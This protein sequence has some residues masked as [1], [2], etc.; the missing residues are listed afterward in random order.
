VATAAE[1]QAR[2]R[3]LLLKPPGAR[4]AGKVKRG[5]GDRVEQRR[6]RHE[7][8]SSIDPRPCGDKVRGDGFKDGAVIPAKAR[9]HATAGLLPSVIGQAVSSKTGM[10]AQVGAPV[11]GSA[12]LTSLAITHCEETHTRSRASALRRCLKT[13]AKRRPIPAAPSRSNP[14]TG[15]PFS[16]TARQSPSA[17][18]IRQP[19]ASFRL[20]ARVGLGLCRRGAIREIRVCDRRRDILGVGIPHSP[21]VRRAHQVGRA[22]WRRERPLRDVHDQRGHSRFEHVHPLARPLCNDAA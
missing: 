7:W 19:A 20:A 13:P 9:V 5:E 16:R 22:G 15:L 6:A 2:L 8:L 21:R 10:P 4:R 1:G 12:A 11:P 14:R 17:S 3:E 18:S